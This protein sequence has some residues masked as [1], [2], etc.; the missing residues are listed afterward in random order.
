MKEYVIW[1]IPAMGKEEKLL[2]TKIDGKYI[3]CP[4]MAE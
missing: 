2:L 1:G 3:T 4:N